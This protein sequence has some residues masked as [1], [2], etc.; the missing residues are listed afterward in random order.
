[1]TDT[2]YRNFRR[3]QIVA[4]FVDDTTLHTWKNSLGINHVYLGRGN[5][6]LYAGYVGLIHNPGLHETIKEIKQRAFQD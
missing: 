6:C 1:M 4:N 2:D 5:V 3:S